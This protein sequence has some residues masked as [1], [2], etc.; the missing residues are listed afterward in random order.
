MNSR[1]KVFIA[2]VRIFTQAI[3][4]FPSASGQQLIWNLEWKS[5]LNFPLFLFCGY[6]TNTL[7]PQLVSVKI[8]K[9]MFSMSGKRGDSGIDL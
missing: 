4:I 6:S 9:I 5:L 1:I 3:N 8:S 2:D 7:L